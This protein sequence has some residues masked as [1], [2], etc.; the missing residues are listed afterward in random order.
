MTLLEVI[1]AIAILGGALAVL[2]ELV[3]VGTRSARGARVH[4]TAQ[5]LA[6]SLIGQIT[7]GITP[8]EPIS[9]IIQ[10]F[11]GLRWQYQVQ[12]AQVDQQGLLAVAV[13][14]REDVEP[15]QPAVSFMLVRWMIDPQIELER[16]SEAAAIE[17]ASLGA[18]AASSSG[19]P[20]GTGGPP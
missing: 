16:E 11:G 9:G 20:A 6:E 1:L 15:A 3:R 2:G 10:Q 8:A 19:A 12:I 18:S 14:V 7:S 17:A 4:F 13:T 5:L